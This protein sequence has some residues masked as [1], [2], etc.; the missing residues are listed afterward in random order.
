LELDN[1]VLM[2]HLGSGSLHTHRMMAKLTYE[3][4]VA[5]FETGKPLTPI[6]ESAAWMA[7]F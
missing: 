1:I 3:N 4:L 6:A 7:K 2:P 5:W